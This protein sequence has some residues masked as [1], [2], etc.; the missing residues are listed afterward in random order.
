[1]PPL[2]PDVVL[3]AVPG[4]GPRGTVFTFQGTGFRA[5]EQVNYWLTGPGDVAYDGG[6]TTARG[7]GSILFTFPIGSATQPGDW[8]MSAYGMRSDR[9]GVARFSV[10]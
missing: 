6:Q 3:V 10:T 9:L 2:A 8:V 4:Q 5:N 7:D 1:M